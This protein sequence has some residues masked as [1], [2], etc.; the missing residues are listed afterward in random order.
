MVRKLKEVRRALMKMR[1]VPVPAQGAWLRRVLQGYFA[2]HAVWTNLRLLRSFRTPGHSGLDARSAAPQ[3][4]PS[5]A[6]GPVR[7]PRK[8][9]DS[10]HPCPASPA[11]EALRR[12]APEV[13]AQCGSS[14]RWDLC[15]GRPERAVPTVT[16]WSWLLAHVFA[17]D[18]SQCPRPGCRGTLEVVRVVRDRDEIASVLHGARAPPR[19][20]APGQLA[21]LPT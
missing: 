17:I 13:G 16:T 1:H 21:L 10:A 4:T 9:V 11:G 8:A 15:G 7:A 18:I 14:A 3:S 12:H 2:Y 19:P 20:P 5:H 6:V